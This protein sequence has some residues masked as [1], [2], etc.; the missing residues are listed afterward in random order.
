MMTGTTSSDRQQPT[1]IPIRGRVVI[2]GDEN[3]LT[4]CI[5][6]FLADLFKVAEYMAFD[7]FDVELT[8]AVGVLRTTEEEIWWS[9]LPPLGADV[10]FLRETSHHRQ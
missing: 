3:D 2:E 5:D 6:N 9:S 4:G 8:P 7:R 1:Q 10:H